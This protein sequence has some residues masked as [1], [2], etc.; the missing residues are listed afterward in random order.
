MVGEL[1]GRRP[2]RRSR[3]PRTLRVCEL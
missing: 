1:I 2:R 3:R